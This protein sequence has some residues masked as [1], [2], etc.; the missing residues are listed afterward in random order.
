MKIPSIRSIFRAAIA[1]FVVCGFLIGIAITLFRPMWTSA[2]YMIKSKDELKPSSEN[3]LI[4]FISP[5]DSFKQ[6][7]PVKIF[8][9]EHLIGALSE[10]NSYFGYLCKSGQHVFIGNGYQSFYLEADFDANKTYYAKINVKRNIQFLLGHDP[11]WTIWFT[12][13][14]KSDFILLSKGYLSNYHELIDI[15]Q[16]LEPRFTA[17]K[18]WEDKNKNKIQVLL[19]GYKTHKDKGYHLEVLHREDGF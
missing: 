3:A 8:D 18:N 13:V 15:N 7:G 4:Y 6:V 2:N 9:E 17:L 1:I 11:G 16:Y 19:A 10:P 12:P 5:E 14:K